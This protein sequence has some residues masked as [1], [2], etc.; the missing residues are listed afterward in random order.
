MLLFRITP[1]GPGPEFL[2]LGLC[3]PVDG[4]QALLLAHVVS[5]KVTLPGLIVPE[6]VAAPRAQEAVQ[7]GA[8]DVF[9]LQG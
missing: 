1:L 2:L 5:P 7:V 6:L 8:I 3:N 4:R 9:P